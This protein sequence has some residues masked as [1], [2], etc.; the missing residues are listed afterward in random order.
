I[1]ELA[2]ASVD[3][4]EDAGKLLDEIVPAIAKTS[5]LVQEITSASEEQSSGATQIN[6]AM[7][8]LNQITQQNASATEELA[9]TAE[10][11]SSQ[12]EQLQ[13]LMSYFK[14]SGGASAGHAVP[15]HEPARLAA[16]P[17][18][19]LVSSHDESEFVKF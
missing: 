10:E 16:R 13:Q 5:D 7:N 1:G 9:A 4:A 12:A 19:K 17:A 6:T 8:Q 11:M 3:K 18:M 15:H 14:V 2:G